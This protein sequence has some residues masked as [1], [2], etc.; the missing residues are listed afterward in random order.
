[1][2]A[3]LDAAEFRRKATNQRHTTKAKEKVSQWKEDAVSW[4]VQ[5]S[6]DEEL[7][8]LWAELIQVLGE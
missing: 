3:G 1:V 5:S 6:R 8:R 7:D 4:I 2:K